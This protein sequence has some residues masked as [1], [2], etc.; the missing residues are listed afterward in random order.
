M[1]ILTCFLFLVAT[2]S[3][4]FA[5]GKPLKL[6]DRNNAKSVEVR[7]EHLSNDAV[8][9]NVTKSYIQSKVEKTL[10]GFHLDPDE[11]GYPIKGYLY[12]NVNILDFVCTISVEYVRPFWD[13]EQAG[14]VFGCTVWS[15][16]RL[17]L[18][19]SYDNEQIA[20]ALVDFTEQFC[21][22]YIKQNRKPATK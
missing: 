18:S 17:I 1:K 13:N 14:L 6:P 11:G 10:I 12:V 3:V 9:W 8:Q 22:D 19:S 15:R 4:S 20:K 16:E 2:C 7:V 21:T 5:A